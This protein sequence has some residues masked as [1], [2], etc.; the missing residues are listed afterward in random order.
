MDKK[1]IFWKKVNSISWNY[2]QKLDQ[3]YRKEAGVYYTGLE[4][5]Y[6]IIE[7]LLGDKKN[8]NVWE[9]KFL[10][11]CVG[12]GN[13]VIS[14][15]KYVS[16]NYN[17]T[18]SQ[19]QQLL[20]NI[21]V[22]ESDKKAVD[23]YSELMREAFAVY[24]DYE[25]PADYNLNIGGP[26][27]FETGKEI[28]DYIPLTEYFEETKFDIVVTNPPYK[29]LRA[30]KKFYETLTAF[31]NAK[32]NYEYIKNLASEK[33][34]Y[35]SRQSAN[36]YKYFVEDILENYTTSNALVGL[37]IP[38][39]ILTDKSAEKLRRFIVEENKLQTIG[40]IS[41]SNKFISAKQAMVYLTI[42]K[43][44][45]T[46]D[47]TVT[48]NLS[49]KKLNIKADKLI[50]IDHN[51]S[52]LI[53]ED[54]EEYEK[55]NIL[56][57]HKKIS[58]L[59]FIV[60]M[61]GELDVTNNKRH[62]KD[63]K[64]KYILLRG[65]HI[66]PYQLTLEHENEYVDEKFVSRIPKQKYILN[67]RIACQQISNVNKDKR[68]I[69]API[70]PGYVLANSCN[71]VSIEE[72][73]FDVDLYY[74][75]AVLNSDL[76]N[77]Y[78]KLF[79]SNNHVNNYEIDAL[80]IAL[81]TK[82]TKEISYLTK[83]YLESGDKNLLEK[84]NYLVY[85]AYFSTE[86][87]EKEAINMTEVND[88]IYE[89]IKVKD[90][91]LNNNYVLNNYSYSLSDLDR[92]IIK[93][94]PQ[95]GNWQDLSDET[96][97]KSKR[98]QGIKKSGGRTTLYGRLEYDLPS[99]TVTTYLN[100]PGNGT[101]I[102]PEHDRVLSTREA[103]RL[104]GFHDDFYFVG[105]QR[106]ILTQ[107]GNAVPPLIGYRFAQRI[108]EKT[109]LTKTVD[110]FSGAGG[111]LEGFE[112]AG[113]NHI[114]ANDIEQAACKTLKVNHP[115]LN[116]IEGDITESNVKS[117]IIDLAIKNEVEIICGG[118]PCQGFSLAG[119]RKED[120]SRNQL[121]KDFIEVVQ[122][123]DPKIFMF[124]NVVGLLSHNKGKTIAELKLLFEEIG[125]KVHAQ[126][127][128]FNEHGVPQRRTRVILI[129]VNKKL[130]N[131]VP[132]ELFPKPLLEDLNNQVTV[133]EAIYDLRELKND[134]SDESISSDYTSAY[135]ELM[136]NE[137]LYEDY[138]NTVKMYSEKQEIENQL[139][140]F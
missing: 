12:I 140:L 75:L 63:E 91:K 100:R 115:N 1:Q 120:D 64:D 65:R 116:V 4:L 99:Y 106:D 76:I 24:F 128:Y 105:N 10:E 45:K 107:I 11:P 95:G 70:E 103:A 129:G 81:N 29:N 62:I 57:S 113:M 131:L 67:P 47:V 130:K 44:G 31:E 88:K 74:L 123:T 133:K 2:Q 97:N 5:A 35:S 3:S 104:Q 124:E 40:M 58:E 6:Q 125:Y 34:K 87:A 127:V 50:D 86:G 93:Q 16:E 51:F 112:Q 68:L 49:N 138:I 19:K 73:K 137:L 79:S 30:E 118:P 108:K 26:L 109:G 122:K 139:S 14:Y 98:L 48:K 53:L 69:F 89:E 8:E 37:L 134:Q 72:N 46:E 43:K 25:I 56:K 7:D 132:Q 71:F 121:I 13:F 28:V 38:S 20:N 111:L 33:F 102:H 55:L 85:K 42:D 22:C 39:S 61:R 117:N 78:F 27:I 21:Y 135:I 36:L 119:F 23:L 77:W 15:L 41:E 83:S 114:L 60:N 17:L 80:P 66:K 110:L 96:I 59:S 101:N 92:E 84:I 94:V 32:K 90:Y 52:I 9:M 82:Y 18:N 126:K 54:E 136:K